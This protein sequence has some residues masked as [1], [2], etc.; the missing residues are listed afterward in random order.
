MNLLGTLQRNPAVNS[1]VKKLRIN[2]L[3]DFYL[4]RFPLTRKTASGCVYRVDSVP[5]LVVA[6]EIFATDV[7]ARPVATA[8]PRTFV[9]LGWP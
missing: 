6:R 8:R 3:V 7:Y 9:D 1:L 2:R 4:R 5:S